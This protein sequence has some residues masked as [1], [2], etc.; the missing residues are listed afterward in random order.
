MVLLK[1]FFPQITPG[2]G[3]SESWYTL[4]V[5]ASSTGVI[6]AAM[7]Y[8]I[9]NRFVYYKLLIITVLIINIL[10]GMLYANANNG[11]TLLSGIVKN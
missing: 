11:W 10:G 1:Y 5:S 6:V 4:I 9:I 3:L 7:I 8:S 2:L